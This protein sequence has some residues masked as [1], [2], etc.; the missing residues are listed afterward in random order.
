MTMS[1]SLTE[2]CSPPPNPALMMQV[3]TVAADCHLGGDAGAF[4]ADA[5]REQG[6]GLTGESALVEI[7][8]RLTHDMV[9]VSAPEDRAQFLADGNEDGDHEMRR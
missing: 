1:P 7:E 9:R 2:S 4:L 5:Q 6:H 3:G 8:V